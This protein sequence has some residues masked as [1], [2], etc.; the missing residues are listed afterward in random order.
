[1]KPF[2]HL[3]PYRLEELVGRGGMGSVYAGVHEKTQERVA[4]KLISQTVADEP[5][6]RRRFASE[7]ETLKR[8]H[9]K[10]IVRLYGYGEEQG[11]LFYSMELVEGESL[12]KRIR[13]LK[14]LD[15]LAT[16]DLCIQ[17]CS[18]LKHAHDI[19]VIHRDLKPANLLITEA[20]AVKLVDFGIAKLFGFGEQTAA[21][22]VLGTADY[23]A[24]E[25]AGTGAITPRTDLYA[26]GSL[27]YAML[28]GRPPFSGKKLTQVVE[29]LKRER[30]VPI[31]LINPDLPAE[32]VQLVH[33]L[34]QKKPDDRPPTALS[35]MNRLKATR[36]GLQRERT[37]NQESSPTVVQ[38]SKVTD[39]ESERRKERETPDTGG[40]SIQSTGT[41]KKPVSNEPGTGL[42]TG[43]PKANV[44]IH[45]EQTILSEESPQPDRSDSASQ[46][47]AER[48]PVTTSR[49]E[50]VDPGF[51]STLFDES[52]KDS[53]AGKWIQGLSVAGMIAILL[54]G[55]ALFYNATR[56]P[57][58]NDL[59][60]SISEARQ[61]GDLSQAEVL[62]KQF[63]GAYGDDERAEDVRRDQQ[64]IRLERTLRRFRGKALS[65]GGLA[66]L[67][68]AEQAFYQAMELRVEDPKTA[69]VQLNAWQLLF[70][71]SIPT[72]DLRTR[73]LASFVESEIAR[74]GERPA[75]PKRD[76]RIEDI[77]ERI[78]ASEKISAARKEATLKAVRDL[79]GDQAWAR[80]AIEEV[81]GM[82]GGESP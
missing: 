50:T 47:T 10:N 9:H 80:Q 59:Y 7:V 24:P 79:F 71:E 5:R 75:R 42:S 63:L 54:G 65:R 32:L 58:A 14:R 8:L 3:G 1:M 33:D 4:V 51:S 34:L 30:P 37:L 15:W 45:E 57:S 40:K 21:G 18:A 20:G 60:Q 76:P 62:V 61:D 70:G 82:A 44:P 52:S 68:P 23:M 56:T 43:E 66:A 72:A 35:V 49:F 16:I 38:D 81:Q 17:I 26:L 28:V 6:F 67:S 46:D 74:M 53:A 69:L 41:A 29:A 31:D 2:E 12:Q 48:G 13:R 25:Q 73:Q 11:H 27:M 22:S 78:V 39:R 55:M 64:T 36:V 77:K 19:G